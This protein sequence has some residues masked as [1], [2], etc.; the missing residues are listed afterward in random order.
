MEPR[1][2]SAAR[3]WD[4]GG[5]PRR[6]ALP[7]G[8]RETGDGLLLPAIERETA[9]QHGQPCGD[10]PIVITPLPS[11]ELHEYGNPGIEG[12]APVCGSGHAR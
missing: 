5:V 1:E 12:C 8:A 2:A 3:A 6:K 10:P 9:A 4:T 11:I 7:E